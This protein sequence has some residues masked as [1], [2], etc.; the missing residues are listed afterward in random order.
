MSWLLYNCRGRGK[1]GEKQVKVREP[2]NLAGRLSLWSVA[3]W[4]TSTLHI[5]ELDCEPTNRH[6][7]PF[8]YLQKLTEFQVFSE[9]NILKD[10]FIMKMVRLCYYFHYFV[11]FSYAPWVLKHIV[12][13][14]R[15][16]WNTWICWICCL[17]Q[18][19]WVQ[20]CTVFLH[21]GHLLLPKHF[22]IYTYI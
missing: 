9:V 8:F 1:R 21:F 11:H 6:T 7:L 12:L 15:V 16:M 19:Y 22:C 18:F 4:I 13:Q 2:D 5:S 14:K 10:H 3:S 20:L 17:F